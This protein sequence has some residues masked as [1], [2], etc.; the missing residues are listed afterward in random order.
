MD[1]SISM[2]YSTNF[3]FSDSCVVIIGEMNDVDIQH[4]FLFAKHVA[5]V[6]MSLLHNKAGTEGHAM[7]NDAQ[8][9]ANANIFLIFMGF[10]FLFFL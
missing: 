1:S 10:L 3:P 4:A 2:E 7:E 6:G 5:S 8:I 9:S